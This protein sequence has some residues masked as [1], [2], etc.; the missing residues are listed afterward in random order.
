ME[1]YLYV[2][3]INGP[4]FLMVDIATGER[5]KATWGEVRANKEKFRT[6]SNELSDEERLNLPTCVTVSEEYMKALNSARTLVTRVQLKFYGNPLIEFKWSLEKCIRHLKDE[7]EGSEG[8][9]VYS[10]F[11][12]YMKEF[13]TPAE[14]KDLSFKHVFPDPAPTEMWKLQYKGV[15]DNLHGFTKHWSPNLEKVT[16]DKDLIAD[17]LARYAVANFI[18]YEALRVADFGKIDEVAKLDSDLFDFAD[19]SYLRSGEWNVQHYY[20]YQDFSFRG[21]EIELKYKMD[22]YFKKSPSE[23]AAK[24]CATVKKILKTIKASLPEEKTAKRQKRV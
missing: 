22:R 7:A 1:L 6:L 21:L 5:R 15:S 3:S 13:E 12:P 4:S 19:L 23:E 24:V 16:T 11:Q 9:I 10:A 17:V 2:S 14:M 20:L 18:A 8:A